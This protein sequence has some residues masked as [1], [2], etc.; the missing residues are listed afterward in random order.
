M[1]TNDIY[2]EPNFTGVVTEIFS[3]GI[4]VSVDFFYEQPGDY[5]F[6]S[7]SKPLTYPTIREKFAHFLN[8]YHLSQPYT[9]HDCRHTFASWL[10]D[11]GTPEVIQDRL[12]GHHSKSLDNKVYVHKT[13]KQ[14][15]EWIT[16]LL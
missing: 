4:T 7:R 14:L 3:K 5:L 11:I 2:N 15:R 6:I 10:S 16:L 8:K 13:I 1:T 9:L 12:M